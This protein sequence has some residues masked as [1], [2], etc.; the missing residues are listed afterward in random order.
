MLF[1]VHF[2]C[3]CM[4]YL[5]F[6]VQYTLLLEKAYIAIAPLT[7][8][9]S[10]LVLSKLVNKIID[11]FGLEESLMYFGIVGVGACTWIWF[12]CISTES[13]RYEVFGISA[14]LGIS[15]YSMMVASLA[16]VVRLIGKNL[17]K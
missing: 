8:V 13:K 6:F 7:M 11:T 10:G 15:S 5:V 2:F 14:F 17:G 9:L 4:T 1:H 12:G 16:L 3:V